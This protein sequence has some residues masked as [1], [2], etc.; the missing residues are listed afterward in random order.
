MQENI[1][2]LQ[3][4]TVSFQKVRDLPKMNLRQIL[5]SVGFYLL[6]LL[7]GYAQTA[8]SP[9]H[10][11]SLVEGGG[12]PFLKSPSS[13][14][15]SG[16]YA[17]VA[18]FGSNALEI[19]DVSNPAAPTHKG[20]LTNGTGGAVLTGPRSVTVSGNYAYVVGGSALEIVDIS[21]PAAPTHKGSLTN[22]TGGA[23]LSSP[24]SVFVS[25]IYA[26]VASYGSN[27]LEIVD[28]SNPAAPA[29]T[30]SLADGMSGALLSSPF[31]VFI[32]GNYA[33][34]A[35]YGSSALEIVDVSN[36]AAPAHMGSLINGTGG[37][38]LISPRSVFVSGNYAYVGSEGNSALEIVDVSNPAAPT[39][40]G[41]LTHGTGGAV[42]T[43]P[44]SVTVSGNYAYVGSYSSNALEIVDVSNPA[45]PVHQ[46]SLTNGT[47]GAVLNAPVSAFV[48][49]NYAYVVSDLSS[50]LEI[51]D[52]SNPAAPNH[53]SSITRALLN[54]PQSVFLSGNYVYVASAI[55]NA[56]EIV[57]VSNP[58]SPVHKGSITNGTGGAKLSTPSSVFIA[59]NYAYVASSG[60][61]ALEIVDVSNPAMPV[62]QGS[63]TNGTGGAKLSA[64]SFVFVSGNYAYVA[65]SGSNAL[66]IVDISNPAVPVHQGSLTNGT[67]GA[68]LSSPSSV[69]I[70]GNYAYVASS[71]NNALEIVNVSNSAAPMHQGSLTNGTGGA[72][73]SSPSYV[74]VSGNYAYVTSTG[75]SGNALEIV[76]VDNPDAPVHQGSLTNGTGGASLSS[77]QSVFVSGN[78]AYVASSTSNALEIVDVSNPAA[79]VHKAK[80]TSGTGGALLSNPQSVFVS[81]NY[82]YVASSGSDALEV[83][84]IFVDGPVATLATG[85][86]QTSFTANWGTV[87]GATGYLVDVSTDNFS[88]FVGVYHNAV[89]AGTSLAITGLQPATTYQYRISATVSSGTTLFSNTISALTLTAT[90]TA[91]AA[92]ALAQ[93]S[94]TA[95]WN[96]ITGATEYFIDVATTNGFGGTILSNY[97]NKSVSGTSVNITALNPSTTYYY[98]VRSANASGA[99]PSSNTITALTISDTPTAVTASSATQTSFI[100]NWNAVTGAT[101]YFIDVATTNGF[102]ASIISNY[103]N[104]PVAGISL[105]VTGLASGT[106][107]YYRVRSTNP[108]GTSPSSNTI[109]QA[110]I[111]P[112]PVATT[113]TL[114]TQISFT[115]NWDTDTGA[116]GY[117]IDVA[118]TSGF[119]GSI[120]SDYNNKPVAGTS[121]NITGLNPGTTYYYQVRAANGSGTSSSSNIITGPTIPETPT[122]VAASSPAQTS[123]TANWNSITGATGYFIDVATTNGFGGSII[124][125]YNNQSV[126]GT[127]LSIAGLPS[128][129]TYYY[130]VRSANSSGT[131]PSSNIISQATIPPNP[132][133][134]A[135]T[136]ITQTSFTANWA[137]STGADNYFLDVS[138]DNFSSFISGYNNQ[139]IGNVTS[140]VVS[141]NLSPN[142]TY[143]YRV[144]AQNSV[145]TSGNSSTVSVLTAPSVPVA[146][147]AIPIAQT[148][149]TANW[150]SVPGATGYFIDIAA[151]ASFN[152]LILNNT[153]TSSNFYSATAL[154]SGTTY[155]YRVRSA[156]AG[157][158]STSSN[159]ISAITIPATPTP[160]N[161]SPIA[162]TLFT[163]NWNSVT[164]ATEY[165]IDVASDNS[166][167][168]A[169]ILLNYNNLLVSGTSI[170]VTGLTAGTNYYYRVRA[171]NSS[172]ISGN[173]NPQLALTWPDTPIAGPADPNPTTTSFS[174]NWSSVMSATK[175]LLDVATSSDFIQTV[176]KDLDVGEVTSRI[177]NGLS[178]GATYY[179]R[180]RAVNSSGNSPYSNIVPVHT[181][182]IPLANQLKINSTPS[183]STRTIGF[184]SSPVTVNVTGGIGTRTVAMKYRAISGSAFST[185]NTTD[186]GNDNFEAVV[187]ESMMD[188]LGLEYYFEASDQVGSN[189]KQLTNSYLFK[190]V[191]AS[192]SNSSITNFTGFTGKSS[193]YKMFSVPYVLDDKNFESIF[194]ELGAYNKEVWRLF[195]YD[196][197][198]DSYKEYSAGLPNTIELGK[199][200]WFNTGN[201]LDEPI[202]VGSGSVSQSNQSEP[203]NG[204]TLSAGW[205]QVGNPYPFNIDWPSIKAA[206]P[207]V[208]LNSLNLFENGGYV[209]KDVLASWKGAFVYADNGGQVTF[210]VTSRTLASGRVEQNSLPLSIDG[211]TW[212]L[213]MTLNFHDL[214]QMSTVGMHQDASE[215][216]DK[217][218]DITVPRFI[219]YL[220]MHT[221]H[222]EYRAT[223]FST[224]IVPT[225][226]K[227]EWLFTLASNLS[228][229][230]AQLTWN[231]QA[232]SGSGSAIL[233]IDLTDQNWIDMK[234]QSRYSFSWKEGKQI[235]LVYSGEGDLDPGVTLLGQAYPNPFTNQITIPVLV[236]HDN[237]AVQVE[238]FDLLGRKV[239]TISDRFLSKGPHGLIWDG[240][241]DKGG[242]VSSGVLIYRMSNNQQPKRM[243]KQ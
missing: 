47:G 237:Q 69:F 192:S 60:S 7:T 210:P 99:S 226:A 196:N 170:S 40:K 220:E 239:K 233:L 23:L 146:V 153:P 160:V 79:P 85:I 58:A 195:R 14:F 116:T 65:S 189:Q 227:H 181:L 184:G 37:A 19:I 95:N 114:I 102:G 46:S 27:A 78:Y 169:S 205:N 186:K 204:L 104:Q 193:T 98:Q 133:A 212:Q 216:K 17:Y 158:S 231:Q 159:T 139:P 201:N 117:L 223:K 4:S 206:N 112:N 211:P 229:G 230:P 66:E 120:I 87:A 198:S 21:N 3:R 150:G 162:Q 188:E 128:G 31:S 202:Q 32:S 110:T 108:S 161:A 56:L 29:H 187:Q 59:G 144:R 218:D 68:L 156:N 5:L 135:A 24:F 43:G 36:P 197:P 13:V 179:Y 177:V 61:N 52:V 132:V 41:S 81:G 71:G 182:D 126:A 55:S 213:P 174:T 200:Y 10:A 115:A 91:T 142:T 54:G 90:P 165:R 191:S 35:S 119:G 194:D 131:S 82:A 235:K 76:N 83:V 164:G 172:G 20:S 224:D 51:I 209:K 129:T 73:L 109:S 141:N 152:S 145:G 166:F 242:E 16:S 232:L 137:A 185:A 105:S 234:T 94:F 228:E 88:T 70:S 80:L 123:F 241:D 93:T 86:G 97:N 236:E 208:G 140:Y 89:A 127:S 118:T 39:H 11:G 168:S 2:T 243:I 50:A 42:L 122:A 190:S 74:F 113:A 134:T 9:T 107:Y 45:A 25:G 180:V 72:L 151:D 147:A 214:M 53:K 148:S 38:L 12:P 163:A 111:P 225:A 22:G 155:Y 207:T 26:Y 219:D 28:V 154:N 92:S 199:A 175:Y 171:A 167:A 33:Y 215:S 217:F 125:S 62:H 178:S 77:P 240:K 18:S 49:G 121:L 15:I 100:G 44:R 221:C 84:H 143:Y 103:N 67:S 238:V 222:P 30:G 57:D 138:S 64:P 203:F 1:A 63:L 75:G 8:V 173:S 149:F 106:T 101:G 136:L 124:P 48:S 130:H 34:V 96:A 157:G 6:G 183:V 176:L